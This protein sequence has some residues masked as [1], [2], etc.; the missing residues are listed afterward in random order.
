MVKLTKKAR[1]DYARKEFDDINNQIKNKKELTHYDFLRIRNFKLQ[2]FSAASEEEIKEKTKKAFELAEKNKIKEAIEELCKLHG[3]AIPI[4]S[5]IL[6]MK[7][8]EKYAIIDR[9]LI[10]ELGEKD[11]LNPAYS[12]RYKT[13]PKI[14]VEYIN[15]MRKKAKEYGVKLRDFERGIWEKKTK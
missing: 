11:W 8:P 7:F 1:I 12:P 3:I 6:S 15:L 14:Y 2:N 4:A 9:L 5:T 10:E 13:D